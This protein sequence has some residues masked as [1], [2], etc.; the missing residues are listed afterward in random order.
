MCKYKST[1]NISSKP[2][3]TTAKKCTENKAY[4]FTGSKSSICN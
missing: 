3:T 2:N 4:K 1:S